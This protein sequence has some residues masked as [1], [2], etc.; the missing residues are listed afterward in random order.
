MIRLPS[1]SVSISDLLIV[2]SVVKIASAISLELSL[3]NL[4]TK[5]G[6][7]L[8]R[9][10]IGIGTPIMPVEQINTWSSFKSNNCAT[11]LVALK[12]SLKPKSPVQALAWPEFIKIAL[13]KLP[14]SDIL[15]SHKSTQAALTVDWVNNPVH[16]LFL[17]A[18]I[19]PRSFFRES[20]NPAEIPEK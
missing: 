2:R 7:L 5:T 14:E 13:I 19:R 4:S 17:G 3:D 10:D 16:I 12:E 20:F 9:F 1:I 15:F 11:S 8:I 18:K 6:K